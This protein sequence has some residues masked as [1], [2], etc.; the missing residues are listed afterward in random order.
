MDRSVRP[1]LAVA[2][3]GI[4][5]GLVL[6]AP[7][8]PSPAAAGSPAQQ[9]FTVVAQGGPHPFTWEWDPAEVTIEGRGKVTW[10]N[11]TGAEHHVSFWDGPSVGNHHIHPGGSLSLVFKKPGVHKYRCDLFGHSDVVLVGTE[12]ICVGQCGEITVE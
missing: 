6:A 10:K 5:A 7:V 8:A 11:P 2:A 9:S 1:R 3:A 12:A 4:A